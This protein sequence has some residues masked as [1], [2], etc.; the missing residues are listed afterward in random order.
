MVADK[1]LAM[2]P[3]DSNIDDIYNVLISNHKPTRKQSMCQYT[4]NPI[5]NKETLW[6][7]HRKRI[8]RFDRL[9]RIVKK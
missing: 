5:T 4:Q 6:V 7:C 9:P 8:K 3:L 1:S 2:L